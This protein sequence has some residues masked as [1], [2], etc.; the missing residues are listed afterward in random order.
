M[1]RLCELGSKWSIIGESVFQLVVEQVEPVEDRI[2]VE[3]IGRLLALPKAIA[4]GIVRASVA[5]VSPKMEELGAVFLCDHPY[6]DGV[7]G[8][9]CRFRS[10]AHGAVGSGLGF[11]EMLFENEGRFGQPVDIKL[12]IIEIGRAHV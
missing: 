2:W 4:N 11:V 8:V 1:D 12:E 3:G 9:F 6:M 10:I 7:I 5:M